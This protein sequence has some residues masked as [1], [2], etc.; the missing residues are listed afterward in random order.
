MKDT[1][2]TILT[3]SVIALAIWAFI[4]AVQWLGG[5]WDSVID[6]AYEN[7]LIV[8]STAPGIEPK[9]IEIQWYVKDRFLWLTRNGKYLNNLPEI[10]GLNHFRVFVRGQ[11]L[12][13]FA[14]QRTTGTQK[15]RYEF[16]LRENGQNLELQL[17]WEP[18]FYHDDAVRSAPYYER[19]NIKRDALPAPAF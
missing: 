19:V 13:S 16:L 15:V 1:L 17:K 6:N 5:L 4:A 18:F 7:E 10:G 8:E 11:P 3:L 9:D 12:Y 2:Q 14:V